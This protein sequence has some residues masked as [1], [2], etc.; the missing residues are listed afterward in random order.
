MNDNNN[1]DISRAVIAGLEALSDRD[2]K[3]RSDLIEDL[4]VLKNLLR[5]IRA[6]QLVVASPERILPANA[7]TPAE[8]TNLNEE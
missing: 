4:G 7:Q 3:V 2:V 6:G 1:V 8:E 5:A